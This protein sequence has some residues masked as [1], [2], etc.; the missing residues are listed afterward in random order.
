MAGCA[1]HHHEII[2]V[3]L[4]VHVLNTMQEN[5]EVVV[6]LHLTDRLQKSNKG[7]CVSDLDFL[8][9]LSGNKFL[10]IVIWLDQQIVPNRF[11]LA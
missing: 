7:V 6:N 1:Q 4:F 11:N 2:Q 3:A 5:Y 8:V 10:E 9:F